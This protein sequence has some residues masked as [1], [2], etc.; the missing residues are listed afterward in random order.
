MSAGRVQARVTEL[1]CRTLQR[2]RVHAWRVYCLM[3]APWPG[4]TGP[5]QEKAL[6]YL[7]TPQQ[8][9]A[10]AGDKKLKDAASGAFIP[11]C[12]LDVAEGKMD[13]L[14]HSAGI[15]PALQGTRVGWDGPWLDETICKVHR[16]P[17]ERSLGRYNLIVAGWWRTPAESP[18]LDPQGRWPQEAEAT[19]LLRSWWGQGI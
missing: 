7:A 6:C 16:H 11:P 18:G 3:R 8:S 15:R 1:T 5:D 12:C 4:L 2:V 19:S 14:A 10:T 17:W 13:L 9:P